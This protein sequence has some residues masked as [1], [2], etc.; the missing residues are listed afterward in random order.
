M[1]FGSFILVYFISL[2]KLN[3]STKLM[4]WLYCLNFGNFDTLLRTTLKA[5]SESTLLKF[6]T[7][8][9]KQRMLELIKIFKV[10]V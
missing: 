1:R 5:L 7:F 8:S 9:G 10:T 6:A 2:Q 4:K 3:I